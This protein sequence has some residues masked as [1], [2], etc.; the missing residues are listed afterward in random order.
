MRY[1]AYRQCGGVAL[2][3][4]GCHTLARACKVLNRLL[5]HAAHQVNF[6]LAR[7]Q[8]RGLRMNV[9]ALSGKFTNSIIERM[10]RESEVVVTLCLP[11]VHHVLRAQ[12]SER[13]RPRMALTRVRPAI[14]KYLAESRA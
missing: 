13:I 6:L 9:V 5:K 4:E 14:H 7:Q 10:N 12:L 11:I 2:A 3:V 8:C 1:I